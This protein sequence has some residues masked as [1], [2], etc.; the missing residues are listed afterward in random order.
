M[1]LTW[2]HVN[3]EKQD[4]FFQVNGKVPGI[5]EDCGLSHG[6]IQSCAAGLVVIKAGL[7]ERL[8]VLKPLLKSKNNN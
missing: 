2:R 1:T 7:E 8:F 4:F 6:S 3:D 5:V